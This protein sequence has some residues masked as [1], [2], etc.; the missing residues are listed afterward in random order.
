MATP[1][2]ALSSAGLAATA[3]PAKPDPTAQLANESTFLK[4]LVAQI[5]N[6]NPLNPQDGIQF[7]TQLAQF[8]ELEQVI[9]IRQDIENLGQQAPSTAAAAAQPTTGPASQTGTRPPAM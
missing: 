9:G 2:N 4:L 1:V 6:Q 8:S 5:Q 3:A 7:I